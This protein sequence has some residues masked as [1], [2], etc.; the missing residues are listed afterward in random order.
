VQDGK[1]SC[2]RQRSSNLEQLA[3]TFTLRTSEG[4]VENFGADLIAR[5]G[6]EAPGVRLCFV[7]KPD[8]DSAPLRDGI[9]DLETG[10]S[11]RQ[12]LPE[13][14]VQALFRDRF[15]GV[16]RMG[17]PLSEGRL[18]LP[19]CGRPAHP[20]LATGSRPG[21]IDE[22]LTLGL[23]RKIVT[24]VSGFSTALG[25][26]AGLRPDR[27]CSRA[28]HRNPARRNAW[29][30]PSGLHAGDHGFIAL[31]PEAECRSSASL[32]ARRFA[33]SGSSGHRSTE[34]LPQAEV[35]RENEPAPAV[36]HQ[37]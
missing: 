16:V 6:E 2:A 35:R 22:A 11:A 31:A 10:S 27:Q 33:R 7:Q 29:F 4:F 1:P 8:K 17:H 19:L 12:R 36:I 37:A 3:R 20:R 34:I 18:R 25:A 32:A 26:R 14:R 9:V 24:I 23:E 15:I 30:S 5:V 28:T 13:L 21:P